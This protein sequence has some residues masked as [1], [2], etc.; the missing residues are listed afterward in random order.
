MK[1]SCEIRTHHLVPTC[2]SQCKFHP[3]IRTPEIGTL[4]TRPNGVLISQFS[5]EQVELDGP[6]TSSV[7]LAA[8]GCWTAGIPIWHPLHSETA[9]G[10][11]YTDFFSHYWLRALITKHRQCTHETFS[12]RVELQLH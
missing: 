6:G 4:L 3:E 11:F 12:T 10:T 2:G 5:L 8:L 7:W 9:H 1:T